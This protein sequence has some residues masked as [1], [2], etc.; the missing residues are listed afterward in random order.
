MN[1]LD[2]VK[3]MIRIRNLEKRL[4]INRE[5]KKRERLGGFELVWESFMKC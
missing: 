4:I 5:Y 1:K 2:Q 3:S